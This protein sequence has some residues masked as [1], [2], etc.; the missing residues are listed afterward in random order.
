MARGKTSE[1]YGSKA[2]IRVRW[3][4]E[5]VENKDTGDFYMKLKPEYEVNIT[6]MSKESFKRFLHEMLMERLKNTN[7]KIKV[8]K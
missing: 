1:M 4:E 6:K 8:T 2:K 5:L 7:S 3:R